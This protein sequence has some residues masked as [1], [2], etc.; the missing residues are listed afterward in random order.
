[1]KIVIDISD[2]E[3]FI[4]WYTRNDGVNKY[5]NAKTLGKPNYTLFDDAIRSDKDKSKFKPHENK[6]ISD[7]N[8]KMWEEFLWKDIFRASIKKWEEILKTK[9]EE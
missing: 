9:S 7:H 6:V 1:M 2:N 8:M 4:G 5:Y 3:T